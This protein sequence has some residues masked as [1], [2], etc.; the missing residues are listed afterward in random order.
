M[1]NLSLQK[2]ITSLLSITVCKTSPKFLAESG[3]NF[4][5]EVYNILQLN[6]SD[7]PDRF[8]KL[9][10]HMKSQNWLFNYQYKWGIEKSFGGLVNRA[11]YL[12]ES[13]RAFEIFNKHYNELKNC[14]NDFFPDHG[15]RLFCRVRTRHH[16]CQQKHHC[17]HC[18]TG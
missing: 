3:S 14:Y 2:K 10:P 7:L 8:Q 12:H 11:V 5:K 15:E 4:T 6:F 9:F 13:A 1:N 16:F 18:C 17:P